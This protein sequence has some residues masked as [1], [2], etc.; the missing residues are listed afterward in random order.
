MTLQ[1]QVEYMKELITIRKEALQF[2]TDS[3]K[4][5]RP[6]KSILASL[7]RLQELEKEDG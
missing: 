2:V 5:I 4:Y 7:L 1:E 3:E 6:Y